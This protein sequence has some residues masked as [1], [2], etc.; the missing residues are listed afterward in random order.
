M[1]EFRGCVIGR[2]CEL[3]GGIKLTRNVIEGG[4]RIG[5]GV[6]LSNSIVMAGSVIEDG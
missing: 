6:E 1:G 3:E 5:K 4:C 2:G